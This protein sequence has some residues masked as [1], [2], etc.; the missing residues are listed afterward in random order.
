MY[1]LEDGFKDSCIPKICK[2]CKNMSMIEFIVK[3]VTVFRVV[4]FLIK[5][6][7]KY[8]FPGIYEIFSITNSENLDRQM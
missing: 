5:V 8:N 3:E 1:A 2:S 4:T 6:Y 7:G